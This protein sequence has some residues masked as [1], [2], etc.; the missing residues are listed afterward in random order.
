[1][2]SD[3]HVPAGSKSFD[4]YVMPKFFPIYSVVGFYDMYIA[5]HTKYF[6]QWPGHDHLIFY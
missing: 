6:H 3:V 5:I 1:M 2:V 4:C